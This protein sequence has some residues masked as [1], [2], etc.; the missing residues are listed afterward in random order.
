MILIGDRH[1]N[2]LWDIK[3]PYYEVY[4]CRLQTDY[5]TLPTAHAALYT[6]TSTTNSPTSPHHRQ[7]F[8]S[9]K[10]PSKTALQASFIK[11]FESLEELISTNEC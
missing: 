9:I 3:I 8:T 6:A 10:T 2:G 11:V 1:L 4:K 5:H 7:S